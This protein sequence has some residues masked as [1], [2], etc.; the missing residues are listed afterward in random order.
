MT[1]DEEIEAKKRLKKLLTSST[2]M[3]LEKV[4]GE[5]VKKID[6]EVPTP[7]NM[8][9]MAE[10]LEHLQEI[11]IALKGNKYDASTGIVSRLQKVEKLVTE[12][13]GKVKSPEVLKE[14]I[15]GLI[16]ETLE[17][18][19][20]KRMKKFSWILGTIATVF[21]IIQGYMAYVSYFK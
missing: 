5:L 13:N 2:N 3:K 12:L 4:V 21:T 10:I 6:S 8:G 9:H 18:E 16:E 7:D 20:Q 14:Y 17:E 1:D 11:D 19:A 15:K